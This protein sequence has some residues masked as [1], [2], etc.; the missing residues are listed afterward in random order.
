MGRT[1]AF[2]ILLLSYLLQRFS[3]WQVHLGGEDFLLRPS[4]HL[5]DKGSTLGWT[6]WEY[7]GLDCPFP[8]LFVRQKYHAKRGKL[9]RPETTAALPSQLLK[10]ECHKE[11]CY[12]PCGLEIL[13]KRGKESGHKNWE[14]PRS[15]K[16]MWFHL[17]QS[18]GKFDPKGTLKNNGSRAE[19]QLGDW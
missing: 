19:K 9:R 6:S 11:K 10:Q 15:P 14:V 7:W 8:S 13:H 4:P 2:L 1:S 5:W 12:H 18:V 3:S 16:R 17:K